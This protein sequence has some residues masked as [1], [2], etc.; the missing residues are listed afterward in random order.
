MLIMF[1]NGIIFDIDGTLY[2]YEKC[3]NYAKQ[4]LFEKI[5]ELT[6]INIEIIEKY[7]DNFRKQTINQLDTQSSSHSRILYIQKICEKL[8]IQQYINELDELYWHAFIEKIKLYDHI[9]KIFDF[10]DSNKIKICLLT[11]FSLKLQLC[12][13]SKLKIKFDFIV[14][15]EEVGK[16]KPNKIMFYEALNKLNLPNDKVIMIGDNFEKDI[17]ASNVLD[18]Y[19]FH[20][21]KNNK[22]IFNYNYCLFN[23]FEWL[24]NFFIRSKEEIENLIILSKYFG[25]RFDLVQAGGGNISVK[26]DEFMAIKSSG[27]SFFDISSS[28]NYVVIKNDKYDVPTNLNKKEREQYSN[29]HISN[30]IYFNKKYKP[31]IETPLHIN[32]KKYTLHFHSIQINKF[33]FTENVKNL[34]NILN[35]YLII[36]YFTPGI[37]LALEINKNYNN[38]NVIFL[39]NHGVIFTFDDYSDIIDYIEFILSKI[40]LSINVDYSNYKFVNLISQELKELFGYECFTYLCTDK[41]LN[42][43][44]KKLLFVKPTTPDKLI[45]CGISAVEYTNKKDLLLFYDTYNE[46]PK[47]IIHNNNIYIVNINLKKCKGTEDVLK[48]HIMSLGNNIHFIDDDEIYYLKNWDLEKYRSEKL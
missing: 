42:K 13:L 38:Q 4:I 25:Q 12:K 45:Y 16:E 41:Y 21:N 34:E 15:S 29:Q 23:S 6:H 48:A 14:T 31:S 40:E 2:D 43:I 37:D 11:D 28:D 10:C 1:F 5:N 8:N 17:L 36:D 30:N 44:D 26:F 20:F 32:L 18:I 24:Y 22:N 33:L 19:S 9:E 7:Y 39:K 46:I 35:N 47:I 27:S 3:N